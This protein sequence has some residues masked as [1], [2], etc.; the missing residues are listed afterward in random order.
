MPRWP[1]Q[2]SPAKC[3]TPDCT[4]LNRPNARTGRPDLCRWCF[5]RV[6]RW[7]SV[8]QA[9]GRGAPGRTRGKEGEGSGGRRKHSRGYWLVRLDDAS[10][11]LEH[12][13]VMEQ[14]LGRQ[15]L[16]T[17]TVHHRNTNRDDNR[18]ENLELWVGGQPTGMHV[19]DAVRW[20]EEI[21]GR[22]RGLD[23]PSSHRPSVS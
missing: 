4:R 17:E 12:R 3:S 16:P 13:H 2:E 6:E 22:Y 21:L 19:E 23:L 7:G 8:D 20:A 10:W 11:A 1:S 18:I 14:F 5:R 9:P 15:L